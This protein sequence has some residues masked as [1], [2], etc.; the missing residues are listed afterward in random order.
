MGEVREMSLA[1]TA[2]RGIA[3]EDPTYRVIL[4]INLPSI[5]D[6]LWSEAQDALEAYLI[7][8]GF[9]EVW[10]LPTEEKKLDY[11]YDNQ[12]KKVIYEDLIL[13][14]EFRK[15]EQLKAFY[16]SLLE[17]PGREVS[18]KSLAQEAGVNIQQ[19]DKY[20]PL[21][22]M[23]DL[24]A[25]AS[26][27][28]SSAVRV[29]RGNMKFYLVD[30]ALRNAVLRIGKGLL[31]DSRML[32]LYAENLVF[33]A[34]RRW[35]GVLQIDYYRSGSGREVDFIVHTRPS[36]YL[37]VEVKYQETISPQD[38]V[39]VDHF[40]ARHKQKSQKPIMITKNM[41]DS[42]PRGSCFLL[43]LVHF[44]LMMD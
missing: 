28:R 11:L 21:L 25:H 33:N 12:I 7:E 15:P 9:P 31:S 8:G 23:T 37:P 40:T 42:G 16:I 2:F 29:R 39:G 44:L 24:L 22:E 38:Q 17:Q 43:P 26:K 36:R 41:E 19:V 35:K 6:V 34:L 32:G 18:Q 4:R 20:L 30:L 14:A 27:F 10:S 5:S 13:A 1:G 3:T